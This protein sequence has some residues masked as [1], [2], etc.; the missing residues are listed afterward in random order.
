MSLLLTFALLAATPALSDDD[1]QF[2]K[3]VNAPLVLKVPGVDKVKIIRDVFYRQSP[4]M[5]ADIYLPPAQGT[6]RAIAILLRQCSAASAISSISGAAN[7]ARH[8]K[9][10]GACPACW[11]PRWPSMARPPK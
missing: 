4:S 9:A 6:K 3:L 8:A 2:L 5:R 11:R 7:Q 1:K 10:P